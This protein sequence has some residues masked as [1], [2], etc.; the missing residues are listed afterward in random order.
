MP[1]QA[2]QRMSLDT[3]AS[4]LE[5]IRR[6]RPAVIADLFKGEPI[7]Q[8]FTFDDALAIVGDARV[9]VQNEYVSASPLTK[10]AAPRVDDLD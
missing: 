5:C 2:I 1:M 8:I 9:L 7:R 3:P 10:S 6:R 4:L